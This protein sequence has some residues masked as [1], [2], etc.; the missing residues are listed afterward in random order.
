MEK[1]F[2]FLKEIKNSPRLHPVVTT[3]EAF[4]MKY[5]WALL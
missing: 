4:H 1:M 5:I 2:S 3:H